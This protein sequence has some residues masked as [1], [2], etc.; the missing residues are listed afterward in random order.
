MSVLHENIYPNCSVIERMVTIGGWNRNELLEQL[1]QNAIHLNTYAETLLAD[2]RLI[3]SSTPYRVSTVELAVS[4]LGFP[5]GA[6]TE[7]IFATAQQLGLKLCPLEL[8]P[9]LRMQY[10]DQPEDVKKEARQNQA[11]SGSVTV[12][13]EAISEDDTFPKGFYLRHMNGELWLRGY[14]ADDL[15]SWNA[16]DRFIFVK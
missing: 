13:S 10:T 5:D 8:A 3:I 1:H 7:R 6:T 9:Y 4:N 11:P 14:C 15:H 2:N 16:D 12:A